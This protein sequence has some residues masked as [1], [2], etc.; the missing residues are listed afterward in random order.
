MHRPLEALEITLTAPLAVRFSSSVEVLSRS[1]PL[2]LTKCPDPGPDNRS[3]RPLSRG[4]LFTLLALVAGEDLSADALDRLKRL[5]PDAWYPGQDFETLVN[6]LEDKD[7]S[8]PE[9]VGRGLYFMLRTPLQQAG[10]VS[11]SQL[12]L[13]VPDIWLSATRGDSGYWRT[14]ALGERHFH[15]EAEQPY[16]CLFELGAL[17]G[18]IEAFNGHDVRVNHATCRRR[19]DIFCTFDVRWEE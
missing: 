5:E 10:V 14:R 9:S 7:A 19:G 12:V 6:Q 4:N 3:G 13:G 8:L 17:R 1:A 2:E 18:L 11:A 16:N 15:V